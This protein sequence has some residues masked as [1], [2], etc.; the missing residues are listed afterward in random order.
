[1]ERKEEKDN[2]LYKGCKLFLSKD[3]FEVVRVDYGIASIPFFRV[4]IPIFSKSIWFG[5]KTTKMKPDDKIKL[6]EILRLPCLLSDQHF[7][8]GKILKVFMIYNNVNRIG[9]TF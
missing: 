3:W 7:S 4:D 5:A 8:N 9:Q 1:M 2:S 6:K